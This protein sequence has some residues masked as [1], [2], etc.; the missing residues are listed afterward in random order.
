MNTL[1]QAVHNKLLEASPE[2]AARFRVTFNAHGLTPEQEMLELTEYWHHQFGLLN[3]D[4][5]E[6]RSKLINNI[7]PE[8][9][10]SNFDNYVIKYVIKYNIP[11][12][13]LTV[14]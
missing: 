10:L 13:N 1:T 6:V 3:I 7:K 11:F 8:W 2:L 9:W 4:T 14:S 12:A 5:L